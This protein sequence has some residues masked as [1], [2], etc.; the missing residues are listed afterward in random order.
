M[1][2]ELINSNYIRELLEVTEDQQEPDLVFQLFERLVASRD[3]FLNSSS[4]LVESNQSQVSFQLH[5]LKN[6]FANLGCE[7]VSKLLE[8]MYQNAKNH[9][10]DEVRSFL[11]EF[12]ELSEQTFLQLRSKLKH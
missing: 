4:E 10:L 2:R 6:Q 5:K 9:R 8:D 1:E 3:E 7:A 12:Q 11:P